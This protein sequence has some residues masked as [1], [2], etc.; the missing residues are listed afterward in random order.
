[1][2]TFLQ[3]IFTP[4]A[5]LLAVSIIII[6]PSTTPAFAAESSPLLAANEDGSGD[7]SSDEN[8]TYDPSFT[9]GTRTTC[10][11]FLGLRAWDCDVNTE[12]SDTDELTTMIVMIAANV[13]TDL[14]VAATY[15][16]L[17]YVIYGG[18][19]YIFSGGDVGKVASG[20]KTITRAFI[21]LA[22]VMLTN[23]I[24][25]TIRV[26]LLGTN[27]SFVQNCVTTASGYTCYQT[28]NPVDVF[29]QIIGW[30]LGI[31]GVI[32]A[33]FAVISG[34]SYITSG[35]DIGKAQKARNTLFYALI[36]LAIVGLAQGLTAFVSSL[37]R[38]ADTSYLD[39]NQIA[40]T[41]EYTHEK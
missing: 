25:N 28:V 3:K 30:V 40:I 13:L 34:I 41:K 6:L 33:A 26:V 2:K 15:L 36:G 16:V 19:L 35:G 10:E 37:I 5:L 32:A 20:K 24:L 38:S 11:L 7:G 29:N 9:G 31:A 23:V 14:T 8:A 22:I 4:L 18:Y 1:M 17:G 21:G 27:G 39:N 12:P